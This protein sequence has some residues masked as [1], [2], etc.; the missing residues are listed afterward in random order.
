[1]RPGDLVLEVGPGTGVL[2]RALLAAGARVVTLEKDGALAAAL[3]GGNEELLR[4]GALQVV[5]DDALRWLRSEAAT[6]A[7]PATAPGGR[8]AAAT[9]PASP[10]SPAP[11]CTGDRTTPALQNQARWRWR[12]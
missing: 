6:E 1:V 8:R 9:R 7:F 3:A 5:H 10:P 2:T 4:S 11:P 12:R